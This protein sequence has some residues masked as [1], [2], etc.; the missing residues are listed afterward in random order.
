M[1]KSPKLK[2]K[3]LIYPELCYQIIGILFE[4]YREFGSGYQEKYYQKLT[5]LEFKRCGL[6]YKEQV[7]IPLI[8]KGNRIG[9]YFLDFLIE[10]KVVLELK[11]GEKFSRKNIEQIYSYLKATGLKLG[12]IANF[13]KS[14]VRFKRIVN[15]S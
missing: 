5:A 8:Y 4:I 3:D 11:R 10:N 7:A 13:T 2:R 9:N 1:Q 15:L 6:D 12:I 14:G